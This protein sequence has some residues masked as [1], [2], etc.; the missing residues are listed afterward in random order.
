MQGGVNRRWTLALVAL[1]VVQAAVTIWRLRSSCLF[2]DDFL[3]FMLYQDLGFTWKYLV[4]DVFGQVV[5]AFR[6]V[7]AAY[8]ETFG[9]SYYGCLLLG[10]SLSVLS[11]L[12]FAL[13]GERA[14]APRWGIACAAVIHAFLL[15]YTH[16][17]LWWSAALHT[18]PSLTATLASLYVLLG[19]DGRGPSPKGRVISALLFGLALTFTGKALFSSIVIVAVFLHLRRRESLPWR[20]SIGETL[21]A[22]RYFVPVTAAFLIL[23]VIYQSPLVPPPP[24]IGVAIDFVWKSLSD[25]T[26]AASLGLGSHGVPVPYPVGIGLPLVLVGAYMAVTIRARRSNGILWLGLGGFIVCAQGVIAWKRAG[27]LGSEMARTLRYNVEDAV[28]L[29]LV[30]MLSSSA[31]A[32]GKRAQRTAVALSVAVA[33]VLQLQSSKVHYDWNVAETC[34][35]TDNLKASVT[36]LDHEPNAVVLEARVPGTIIVDWMAPYNTMSR[37]LPLFSPHAKVA[38]AGLAT[39]EIEPDGHAKPLK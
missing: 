8:F 14:G 27:V 39:W 4:R 16:A 3:N 6:L 23:T 15:Q 21:S 34:V 9:P 30:C 19:Q 37:F 36:A 5:P 13:I 10:V 32:L 18:L 33:I 17:Q 2:L 35:Y 24:T 26:V 22:L 28:F 29:L 11:T 1:L 31:L 20:Q 7:Q 38:G 25:G 12:F